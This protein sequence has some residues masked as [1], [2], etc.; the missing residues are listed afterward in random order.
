MRNFLCVRDT[1]RMAIPQKE[2]LKQIAEYKT[3]YRWKDGEI[4]AWAGVSVRTVQRWLQDSAYA[5][6]LA[7]FQ[8]ERRG[9]A[10]T[11]LV[12]LADD[13]I[14]VLHDVAMHGKVEV[15]RVQAAKTLGE[16]IRLDKLDGESNQDDRAEAIKQLKALVQTTPVITVKEL[17]MPLPGGKLPDLLTS[18][19]EEEVI[20]GKTL[21]DDESG[22]EREKTTE[23]ET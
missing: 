10:K 6:V 19:A 23:G 2:I 4:A 5:G 22:S 7:E 12:S 9:D 21:E 8:E 17:P 11:R 1:G 16:W 13:V 20:D 15:A 18:P 3:V 14:S